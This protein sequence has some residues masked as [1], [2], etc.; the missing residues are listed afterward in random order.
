MYPSLQSH[1]T[2]SQR[3]KREEKGKTGGEREGGREKENVSHTLGL[4][5]QPKFTVQSKLGFS[6]A[7]EPILELALVDQA[8]L[9]LTE[10]CLSLPPECHLA[11]S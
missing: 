11:Q 4:Y 7:L 6:V 8:G 10:I 3:E 1:E 9:E 2:L 5:P